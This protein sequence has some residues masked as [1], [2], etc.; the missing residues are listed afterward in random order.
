MAETVARVSLS[1]AGR[2][3]V[4][5]CSAGSGRTAAAGA[6]GA[7]EMAAAGEKALGWRDAESFGAM[8]GKGGARRDGEGGGLAPH[9]LALLALDV[10]HNQQIVHA[11]AS[12][13]VG[14]GLCLIE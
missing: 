10:R 13:N 14:R 1:L 11:S 3:A 12:H 4:A 5:A 7:D 2:S 6:P 8:V 9:P